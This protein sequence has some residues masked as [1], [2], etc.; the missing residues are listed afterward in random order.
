MLRC[1]VMN[2]TDKPCYGNVVIGPHNG[3]NYYPGQDRAH[4]GELLYR[5]DMSCGHWRVVVW[6]SVPS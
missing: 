5:R 2:R 1:I 3:S 4:T 6:F